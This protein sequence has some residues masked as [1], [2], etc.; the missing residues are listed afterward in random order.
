[1]SRVG[2]VLRQPQ[3][4]VKE[5]DSLRGE[6]V[7]LQRELQRAV[8]PLEVR[9]CWICG[10]DF[11][12]GDGLQKEAHYRAHR[13]E[14]EE[15]RKSQAAARRERSRS[16]SSGQSVV[17]Y[18]PSKRKRSVLDQ[19]DEGDDESTL[20]TPRIRT[21]RLE[22]VSIPQAPASADRGPVAVEPVRRSSRVRERQQE[23]AAVTQTSKT[24]TVSTKKRGRPK[25]TANGKSR[26][27]GISARGNGLSCL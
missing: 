22:S 3:E 26:Q 18:F 2:R 8:G 4:P 15:Y 21:R 20:R 16:R 25:G 19:G 13:H 11:D 27:R 6:I 7:R 12:D 14:V 10:D 17:P 9:I 24:P 1:M 23:Q 5:T